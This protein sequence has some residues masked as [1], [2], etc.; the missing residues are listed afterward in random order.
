MSVVQ[1]LSNVYLYYRYLTNFKYTVQVPPGSEPV[2][3]GGAAVDL[4]SAL[5]LEALQPLLSNPEFLEKVKD[6]IPKDE[7]DEGKELSAA[8]LKGTVQSPQFKQVNLV[9]KDYTVT[10]G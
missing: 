1:I 10:V 7:K 3:A 9:S 2:S 8:D 5:T 4:S 6:F